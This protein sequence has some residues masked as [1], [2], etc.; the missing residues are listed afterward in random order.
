MIFY[1]YFVHVVFISQYLTCT[2]YLFTDLKTV[3]GF[4]IVE[5]R[6][7][8]S[9][10]KLEVSHLIGTEFQK[11]EGKSETYQNMITT[12]ASSLTLIRVVHQKENE[13]ET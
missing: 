3:V 12:K 9:M 13:I 1:L 10:P 6:L 2:L 7:I 4:R 5:S 11:S 8:H